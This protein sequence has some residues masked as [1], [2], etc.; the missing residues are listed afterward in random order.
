MWSKSGEVL[1]F[2]RLIEAFWGFARTT[3]VTLRSCGT[4]TLQSRSALIITMVALVRLLGR[5]AR[6]HTLVMA[7]LPEVA[8]TPSSGSRGTPTVS[9]LVP[10]LR[11]TDLTLSGD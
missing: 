1:T 2:P 8:G 7:K 5:R 4:A 9:T 10:A 3:G 6:S 11:L